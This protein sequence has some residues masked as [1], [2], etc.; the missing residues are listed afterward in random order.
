VG[1]RHSTDGRQR[2][3]TEHLASFA[4]CRRLGADGTVLTLEDINGLVARAI[5]I[6]DE[7]GLYPEVR[8][9]AAY[10]LLVQ[11]TSFRHV[12]PDT[13]RPTYDRLWAAYHRA[14]P[15]IGEILASRSRYSFF[16]S[17]EFEECDRLTREFAGALAAELAA[18]GPSSEPPPEPDAESPTD[19]VDGR[20]AGG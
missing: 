13:L 1:R 5:A 19:D 17:A 10:T 8:M 12:L 7:P 3:D 9:N 11:V 14:E 6:L 15:R 18:P 20:A 2:I 16:T 4:S